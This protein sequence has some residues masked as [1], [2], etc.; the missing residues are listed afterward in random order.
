MS[1]DD[2]YVI[3]PMETIPLGQAKAFSLSRVDDAGEARPF[4][5]VIVRP[6]GLTY[7]GYVNVCPHEGRWLNIGAGEFFTRDGKFLRCGRHGATFDIATG[8]CVEGPCKGKGLEA[9]SISVKDGEVILSGV[10]LVEDE[11][12][13]DALV[14]PDDSMEIMIHPG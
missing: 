6:A 2:S 4:S 14:E 5:I 1:V 11:S 9:I 8:Q 13:V 7:Y 10:T 12:E 3:C